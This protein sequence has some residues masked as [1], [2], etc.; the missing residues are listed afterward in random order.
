MAGLVSIGWLC[1]ALYIEN[2]TTIGF[3]SKF[4]LLVKPSVLGFT[5]LIDF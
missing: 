3:T 2:L 4:N 5:E 1:L